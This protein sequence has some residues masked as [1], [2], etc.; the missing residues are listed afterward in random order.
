M[1]DR[2][3]QYPG[4]YRISKVTNGVYDLE[5]AD[6]PI[7]EGTPLNAVNLLSDAT[8]EKLGLTS[9][10]T[11]NDAINKLADGGS[12]GDSLSGE[13]VLLN[14]NKVRIRSGG[15]F[16]G[17]RL[18]FGDR[19]EVYLEETEDGTLTIHSENKINLSSKAVAINDNYIES[20]TWTPDSPFVAFSTAVGRYIRIGDNVV[21]SWYA[22]GNCERGT[23]FMLITGL[24]YTP[25]NYTAKWYS[26]GGT[27]KNCL[28]PTNSVFSG[29]SIESTETGQ[30]IFARSSILNN[31]TLSETMGNG[32]CGANYGTTVYTSGTIAYKI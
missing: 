7:E 31:N 25:D 3:A 8:A 22:V 19:E 30:G 6:E 32:Y 26:G 10:A 16:N 4:R 17:A 13:E 24:P 11:V 14:T 23:E 2:K 21:V 28:T 15:T 9:D 18:N 5:R 29:Y 27:F 12:S 1:K 20:G